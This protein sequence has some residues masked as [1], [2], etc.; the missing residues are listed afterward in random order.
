MAGTLS[1]SSSKTFIESGAN[2]GSIS[3]TIRITL[4]DDTF[5]STDN[6]SGVIVSNVPAGLTAVLTRTSATTATLSLTGKAT[7]NGILNNVA[8]LT[9]TFTADNFTSGGVAINA[10]TSDL[11]INFENLGA[12]AIT[13]TNPTPLGPIGKAILGLSGT[14]TSKN[15][16]VHIFNGSKDLGKAVVAA[17]GNWTFTV[18]PKSVPDGKLSLIAKEMNGKIVVRAS[19]ALPEYTLDTKAPAAPTVDTKL[20]PLFTKSFEPVL[21]GKAEKGALVVVT[22]T[23]NGVDKVLNSVTTDDKG[24]W[25]ATSTPLTDNTAY[26]VTAQATDAAGNVSVASKPVTLTVDNQITVPTITTELPPI[27]KVAT[28]KLEGTAEAGASVQIKLGGDAFGKAVVADKNGIWKAT[29]KLDGAAFNGN[30]VEHKITVEASDAAGNK[31]AASSEKILIVDTVV[32]N[33][34]TLDKLAVLPMS[35]M[36]PDTL[37]GMADIGVTVYVY[38][39]SVLLGTATP[40]LSNK[41]KLDQ[42]NFLV[43][44]KAGAQSISV[45]AVDDAGNISKASVVQKFTFDPTLDIVVPEAPT[46]A[47]STD[48]TKIVLAYN[49]KLATKTADKSSFAVTGGHAVTAVKVVGDKVELTLDKAIKIAELATV[50][51]SY[52]PSAAEMNGVVSKTNAAIQDLAGNDALKFTDLVVANSVIAQTVVLKSLK[53]TTIA[54]YSVADDTINLS[55]SVF[56]ALGEKGALGSDFLTVADAAALTGGTVAAATDAA[57]IIYLV[58]TGAL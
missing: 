29:V 16:D 41:W 8:D 13:G 56:K 6:L 19:D 9:V 35:K 5:K 7:E 22:L 24:V 53:N 30:G 20:T 12:L 33:S 25:T 21:T 42:D 48:G 45:K 54:N 34:P 27:S 39:G 4:K 23:N 14:A 1:Y 50:E 3:N 43:V 11:E 15:A 52:T 44:P 31:S 36:F 18:A 55:K 28:Q 38:A 40:D 57:H 49:E 51:V 32:P 10:V 58:A 37:S 17:D 46:A 47:T 2:D 26:T